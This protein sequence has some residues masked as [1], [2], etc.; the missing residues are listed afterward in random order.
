MTNKENTFINSHN[1]LAKRASNVQGRKKG[2][3][4]AVIY[5]PKTESTPTFLEESF[6]AITKAFAGNKIYTLKGDV[7]DGKPVMIK[8]VKKDPV[9]GN[10]LHVD[11]YALDMTATMTVEVPLD[12]QG[13]PE[14]VKE[15]GVM[16]E[17]RRSI[18]LECPASDIPKTIVV[19]VSGLNI[20]D[21]LSMGDI[22]VPSTYKVISSPEY[23]VVNI[24]EIKTAAAEEA[25]AAATDE[26]P[27]AE[28][29]TPAP[30][31]EGDEKSE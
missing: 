1:R 7:L 15:G 10:I 23:A 16:Q 20:G 28:G 13:E 26:A 3:I 19:D 21:T 27:A 2:L 11:L 6:F 31:A 5:G 4:P 30:A 18:E 8:E 14:G 22:K 29:E 9:V 25:E 17:V 24:S 12:F